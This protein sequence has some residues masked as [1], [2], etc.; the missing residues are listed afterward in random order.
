MDII[1]YTSLVAVWLWQLVFGLKL[2]LPPSFELVDLGSWLIFIRIILWLFL[3][4]V[5]LI[6]SKKHKIGALVLA[7]SPTLLNL[8]L[9]DLKNTIILGVFLLLL[10]KNIKKPYLILILCLF[11]GLVL[12]NGRQLPLFQVL[13]LNNASLEV[14]ERFQDESLLNEKIEIPGV[15]RRISYNKYF[16]VIK[17][18]SK[19]ILSFINPRLWFFKELD[20]N[21]GKSMVIFYWPMFFMFLIGIYKE[22]NLKQILNYFFMALL[23]YLL[24]ANE[25]YLLSIVPLSLLIESGFI[26]IK[27]QKGLIV[28]L[29]S[30][31]F[32]GFY[33]NHQDLSKN[34]KYW[35]DNRIIL[36]QEIFNDLL[37]GENYCQYFLKSDCDLNKISFINNET[38]PSQEKDKIYI[39][40]VGEYLGRDINNNYS[41][42]WKNEIESM[43]FKIIKVYEVNDSIAYGLGNIVVKTTDE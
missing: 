1:F 36:Y 37:K 26:S 15:L 34:Q 42:N 13:N 16:F 30:S 40:F 21:L 10:D 27:N 35:F 32:L 6:F 18:L 41:S 7:I 5:L 11:I 9:F 20:G 31:V 25:K 3:G 23:F 14:N 19:E 39:G 33:F 4:L 22:K 12:S 8:W 28:V 38:K 24:S 2:N 29:T 17:N 43:G